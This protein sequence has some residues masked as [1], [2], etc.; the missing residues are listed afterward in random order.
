MIW[1]WSRQQHDGAGCKHASKLPHAVSHAGV[2]ERSYEQDTPEQP[3]KISA[4]IAQSLYTRDLTQQQAQKTRNYSNHEGGGIRKEENW[5]DVQKRRQ[6]ESLIL[7]SILR[8]YDY[9]A[10][11]ATLIM[12]GWHTGLSTHTSLP[13][14]TNIHQ[15]ERERNM[16]RRPSATTK[17]GERLNV[18]S[19][20]K[21]TLPS[22]SGRSTRENGRSPHG[23][24]YRKR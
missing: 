19:G 22:K 13:R 17:R 3:A 2:R 23:R 21:K 5:T 20:K 18:H 14:L 10:S 11:N 15:Y 16:V 8:F 4:P 7:Q 12:Q 6:S 24:N 9:L 1:I